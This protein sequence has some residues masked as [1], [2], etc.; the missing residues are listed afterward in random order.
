[1]TRIKDGKKFILKE[2]LL[3]GRSEK[4]KKLIEYLDENSKKCLKNLSEV[5][6]NQ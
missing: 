1:V 6:E 4:E 3:E 5:L 2:S